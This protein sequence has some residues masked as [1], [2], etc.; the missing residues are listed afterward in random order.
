MYLN[1]WGIWVILPNTTGLEDVE[2][3][4]RAGEARMFSAMVFFCNCVLRFLGTVRSCQVLGEAVEWG[5][6][7]TEVKGHQT[8]RLKTL[9]KALQGNYKE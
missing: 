5:M 8:S 9:Q 1:V 6:E 4:D 7:E 3:A 2:T